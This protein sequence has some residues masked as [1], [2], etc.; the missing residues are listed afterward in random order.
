MI[1][2]EELITPDLAVKYLESAADNRPISQGHVRVLAQEMR[3]GRWRLTHQGIALNE[4]GQLVDGQHRLW[5]VVESDLTIVMMVSHGL[6]KDAMDSLDCGRKRSFTD[7]EVLSGNKIT[8]SH[9]STL[10]AMFIISEGRDKRALTIGRLRELWAV[11]ADAVNFAMEVFSVS[12]KG[13]QRGTN[14]AAIRGVVARA[15]YTRSRVRLEQFANVMRT[16]M[17]VGAGDEAAIKLRNGLLLINSNGARN[18][19]EPTYRKA[20]RALLSFIEH[21][22]LKKI[23]EAQEELFPVPGEDKYNH[24]EGK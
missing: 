3:E 6:T 21:E 15:S 8:K 10:R 19:F 14:N 1:T 17:A 22:P 16:G 24:K 11:H 5:A 2:K 13:F 20:E 7:Y 18:L 23:Y 12:G 9:E 4:A